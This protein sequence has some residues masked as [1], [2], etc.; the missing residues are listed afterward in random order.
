MSTA[1]IPKTSTATGFWS[2]FSDAQV[3]ANYKHSER[4]LRPIRKL[5]VKGAV[6]VFFQRSNEIRLLVSGEAQEAVEAIKTSIKGDRLVIENE[7]FSISGG[8]QINS[9]HG[10][11]QI[12]H[13]GGGLHI[14]I[15]KG[16][17]QIGNMVNGGVSGRAVVGIAL[18]AIEEV[19]IK[20]SGDVT[21]LDL[22]QAGIELEIQ[23][24]GDINASGKVE[25]LQ[26]SITGSG[27]MN[28]SHLICNRAH[29]S[30]S[31]SGDIRAYVQQAVTASV[32]GSGDIVVR[33]NPVERSKS[34]A[35]SG[36]VKFK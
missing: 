13:L 1:E 33:G 17:I 29:L 22:Q 12:G 24:S 5:V 27:D 32:T 31:G 4:P 28:V 18:P 23:G 9:S 36:S 20:G 19:N 2:A 30:I 35:G 11:I 21:L 16:A 14:S 8:I 6:D 10:N 34:V 15:G 7:G 25:N 3:G 26:V